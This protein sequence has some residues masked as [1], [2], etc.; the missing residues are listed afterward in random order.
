MI[1]SN[2]IT[3]NVFLLN[4]KESIALK[5]LKEITFIPILSTLETGKIVLVNTSYKP[6]LRVV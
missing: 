3:F 6:V 1:I 4:T 5:T 2:Y